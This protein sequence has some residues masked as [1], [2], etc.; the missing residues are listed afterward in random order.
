MSEEIYNASVVVPRTILASLLINGFLG[1]SM[2]ITVLFCFEDVN[3]VL[4]SPTGF[5]FVQIFL[6]GVG[7]HA[8]TTVMIAVVFIMGVCASIGCLA[9]TS[10]MIWSF[11]RDSGLPGSVYLRKVCLNYI[12][13]LL[14]LH[15]RSFSSSMFRTVE[16][17]RLHN[18]R[19]IQVLLFL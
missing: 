10:R 15:Q 11:A 13:L 4:E 1:F 2:L 18:S 6:S 3:A 19:F 17:T 9:S 16:L 5:P 8:G 12:C 7:S 14:Y